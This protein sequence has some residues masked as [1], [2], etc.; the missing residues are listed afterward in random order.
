MRLCERF[1]GF[2]YTIQD[3]LG[4]TLIDYARVYG[5]CTSLQIFDEKGCFLRF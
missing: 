3:D 5:V 2:G 4:N 1:T